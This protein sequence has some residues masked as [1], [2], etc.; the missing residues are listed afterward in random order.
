MLRHPPFVA[1]S[2]HLSVV[3]ESDMSTR[4]HGLGNSELNT[5]N[6][7]LCALTPVSDELLEIRRGQGVVFRIQSMT[8]AICTQ[9]DSEEP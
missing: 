3:P 1:S 5:S 4:C 2:H 7:R 8:P 6:G 9:P